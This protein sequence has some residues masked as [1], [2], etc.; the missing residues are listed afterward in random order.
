MNH[1]NVTVPVGV[2]QTAAGHRRL[3][4]HRSSPPAPTSPSHAPRC[5]SPSPSS[6]QPSSPS[7]AHT[8]PS[9]RCTCRHRSTSPGTR[10]SPTRPA[11]AGTPS[12]PPHRPVSVNGLDVAAAGA[13]QVPL[14]NHENVTVPVGVGRPACPV[15]VAWSCTDRPRRHRRHR[16]VGRVVDHR[17]RRRRDLASPSTAHTARSSR[18]RCRHPNR[19]PGTRSSPPRCGVCVNVVPSAT[20]PASVNALDVAAAGAGAGAVG[21]PRE[22]HR[23]RRRRPDRP[24]RHRRLVMHRSCPPAPTSPSHARRC[25]SPSPSIDATLRRPSTAHTARSSAV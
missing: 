9:N 15:T 12:R 4:V 16:R 22:R 20:P 8:A 5:G 11:S 24:A 13:V 19:S 25:G 23:P 2:P 10:N 14:V 7:T 3:V 1:V 18:C 17:H 6:T 21:E